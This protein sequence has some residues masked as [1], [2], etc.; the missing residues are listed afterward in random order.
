MQPIQLSWYERLENGAY[1]LGS[2]IKAY[3][4]R[5]IG[6]YVVKYATIDTCDQFGDGERVK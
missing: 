1:Q 5:E 6:R 2:G 4:P 3:V